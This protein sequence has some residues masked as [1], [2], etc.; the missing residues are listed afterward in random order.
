MTLED[1]DQGPEMIIET[2]TEDI[3]TVAILIE[4]LSCERPAIIEYLIDM[5][6]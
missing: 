5:E 4:L 1:M 2:T 3:P 6:I